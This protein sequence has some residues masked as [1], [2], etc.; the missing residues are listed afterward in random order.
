MSERRQYI[1]LDFARNSLTLPPSFIIAAA[2][3]SIRSRVSLTIE[4]FGRYLSLGGDHLGLVNDL[5]SYD[6]ELCAFNSGETGDMINLVA[7]M[8]GVTSLQDTTDAKSLAWALHLQI[9]KQMMEALEDLR[10]QGL[11]DEKW[12]FL[13]TVASTAVGN[14]IFCMTTSRYGAARI[15]N[16][17]PSTDAAPGT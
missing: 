3:F 13:E 5:A 17:N 12:W 15:R 16:R 6:K 11:S 14:V 10:A 7:V 9:E 4:R 8:K 2:K 1:N